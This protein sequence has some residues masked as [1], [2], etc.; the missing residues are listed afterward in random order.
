MRNY[1]VDVS[2]GGCTHCS[3]YPQKLSV[4]EVWG[5]VTPTLLVFALL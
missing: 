1:H 2:L 3:A 5:N 4:L